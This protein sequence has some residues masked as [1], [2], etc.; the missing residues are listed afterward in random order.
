MRKDTI[1]M[2]PADE[3]IEQILRNLSD[4]KYYFFT[5]AHCTEPFDDDCKAFM[6]KILTP[7]PSFEDELRSYIPIEP[8]SILHF[9]LGDTE[10]VANS[11]TSIPQNILQLIKDNKEP[12]S[13]LMS[14]SLSLKNHPDV[15]KEVYTLK[16]I[17]RHLG[18]CTDIEAIK[19]TLIDFFFLSRSTH[20]KTYSCY[21]WISGF[22]HWAHIIYGIPLTKM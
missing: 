18:L 14:D 21:G 10:M 3:P 5:N 1:M 4:D 7:I 11:Q 8:Y 13:I 16:T 20:I 22:V 12:A 19:G 15:T 6:K 17:P 2:I 9:R